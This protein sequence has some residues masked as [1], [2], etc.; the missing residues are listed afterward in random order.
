[1]GERARRARAWHRSQ[2][3]C[4]DQSRRPPSGGWLLGS[5]CGG[6]WPRRRRSEHRDDDRT[7][8]RPRSPSSGESRVHVVAHS[9][10]GV[11]VRYW[12]DVLDGQRRAD[13]IVTLGA[14]HGGTP[15]ARLVVLPRRARDLAPGSP[16]LGA[17]NDYRRWTTI[18]GS[19]DVVVPASSSHL[20]TSQR[21]D[22]PGIGDAGLLTSP[23]VGESSALCCSRPSTS[24]PSG[25][26]RAVHPGR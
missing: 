11:A 22:L 26:S 3:R 19:L 13:A 25:R 24:A 12:H 18:G 7:R 1:M 17:R 20:L 2:F 5:S 23:A 21:I 14:P 10:G 6:L 16:F 9:L 15:W 4:V 8:R